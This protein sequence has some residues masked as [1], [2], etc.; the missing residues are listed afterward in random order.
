MSPKVG[1]DQGVH[2]LD[3][4][5]CTGPL[6][7]VWMILTKSNYLDA[8]NTLKVQGMVYFQ[9]LCSLLSYVCSRSLEYFLS[10]S[11]H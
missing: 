10:N 4:L 6:I 8:P 11:V 1:E 3:L 7:S 5:C 2:E 9:F